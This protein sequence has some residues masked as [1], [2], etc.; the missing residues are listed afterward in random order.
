[1]VDLAIREE[2]EGLVARLEGTGASVPGW[3]ENTTTSTFPGRF[4]GTSPNLSALLSKV[5]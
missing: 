5:N 3:V 1:V 2:A 4:S